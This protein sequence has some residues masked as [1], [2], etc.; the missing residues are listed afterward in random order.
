MKF[1]DILKDLRQEKN[2]TQKDVAAACEVTTTCISQL[3]SGVRNPTGSTLRALALYFGVSAD[4]LL[5]LDDIGGKPYTEFYSYEEKK[6]IENYRKL[7]ENG[8]KLI[9]EALKTLTEK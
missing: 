7:N 9:N 2:V 5:N 4:Y 3:E 1:C 8:K 6:V